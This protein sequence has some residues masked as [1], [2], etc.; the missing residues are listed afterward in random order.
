M[1][2]TAFG[3]IRDSV[4][5]KAL[6]QEPSDGWGVDITGQPLPLKRLLDEIKADPESAAFLGKM[7]DS[8]LMMMIKAVKDKYTAD[9]NTK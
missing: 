4:N 8:R 7:L 6:L 3:E 2:P 9:V 1:S 5:A